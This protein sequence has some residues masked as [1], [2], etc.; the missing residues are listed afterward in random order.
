MTVKL[1]AIDIDET[2]VDDHKQIPERNRAA[3]AQAKAAGITVALCT[4]RP[5]SGVMPYLKE[6]NLTS[7]SDYVI[8]M[9]GAA[10]V[11]VKTKEVI[12]QA[13]LTPEQWRELVALGSTLHINTHAVTT[14]STMLTFHH[15]VGYYSALDAYFTKMDIF[16]AQ[17]PQT[18]TQT[19]AKVMWADDPQKIDAGVSKLPQAITDNYYIVRT[20]PHFLEFAQPKA[21]KGTAMLAL[22]D[23][24]AIDHRATMALGDQNND[25]TMIEA[26]GIG[27][28]MANA[29]PAI[30]QLASAHTLD[31]NAGGVGAAIEHYALGQTNEL[32]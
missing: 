32:G 21:T 11:N 8:L 17:D 28:A 31:N 12:A 6:L 30:K 16:A 1:I 4:G 15:R 27:V 7:A 9:N 20:A 19:I 22:A 14:N 23:Y 5:L 2:L 10:I 24:L 26:A 3:I 29:I 13:A 18:T 25:A